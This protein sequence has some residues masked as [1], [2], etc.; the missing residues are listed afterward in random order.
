MTNSSPNDVI[1]IFQHQT[2]ALRAPETY[3]IKVHRIAVRPTHMAMVFLTERHAWKL[4]RPMQQG[5]M[6]FRLRT[7]RLW[8]T[9]S[10]YEL[11]NY[12]A[13]GVCV[14]L[15]FLQRDPS[16]TSGWILKPVGVQ[17][18]VAGAEDSQS[19]EPVLCM[20]RL[21]TSGMMDHRIVKGAFT[22]VEG[23]RCVAMLARRLADR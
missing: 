12:F 23:S 13:P 11:D 14:G 10:E 22:P 17:A 3:P 19:G 4:R 21:P 16:R 8:D 5:A 20:H 6:D 7:A 15:A 2:F 18:F 9:L 1:R